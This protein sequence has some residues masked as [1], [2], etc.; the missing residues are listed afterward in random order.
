M[1]HQTF[2]GAAV[3]MLVSL[4]Q[5]K[6]PQ[7]QYELFNGSDLYVTDVYTHLT[8]ERAP[9]GSVVY[10]DANTQCPP[11]FRLPSVKE[12]LSLIDE[13][14]HKEFLDR[15]PQTLSIDG[16]A[17]G[18]ENADSGEFWTDTFGK[19]LSRF[20][21]EMGTGTTK[22]RIPSSTVKAKFRCVRY[23]PGPL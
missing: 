5:A 15:M 2:L 14:Q 8:W 16:A 23:T 18:G 7:D 22:T 1:K 9:R 11:G 12:L 13:V 6:A 20:T 21:V 19:D 17:F 3:L 4:V 10:N